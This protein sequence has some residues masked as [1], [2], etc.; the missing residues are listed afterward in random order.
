MTDSLASVPL[1]ARS[2]MHT[3]AGPMSELATAE[4]LAA[5]VFD[6]DRH[7]PGPFDGVPI[8]D[9]DVHLQAARPWLDACWRGEDPPARGVRLILDGTP[10]QRAVE[11]AAPGGRN[12]RGHPG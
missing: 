3:P 10:L 9:S 12:A 11:A 4:G 5:L 1:R 6:A 2:R 7:H 8:D